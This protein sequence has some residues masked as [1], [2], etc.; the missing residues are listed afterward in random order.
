VEERRFQRRVKHFQKN[1]PCQ[2]RG[3]AALPAPRKASF[4]KDGL[5]PRRACPVSAKAPSESEGEIEGNPL[6]SPAPPQTPGAP[7]LAG[8]ARRGIPPL[9][10]SGDLITTT[11]VGA[12]DP[13][14][15]KRA[16]A[17]REPRKFWIWVARRSWCCDSMIVEVRI[18]ARLQLFQPHHEQAKRAEACRKPPRNGTESQRDGAASRRPSQTQAA[19]RKASF[20]KDGLQ[21][22]RACLSQ[23]PERI[24]GRNRR[25]PAVFA[26]A[27]TDPR[28]PGAPCLAGFAR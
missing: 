15:L 28:V 14:P 16:Q 27:T 1:K 7:C 9:R 18:R 26:R 11:R 23:G 10:P 6:S 13:R 21:P 5:Q 22:R 12:G 8:F 17:R 3:R 19:P 4:T 24:R 25:E 20:S 2:H